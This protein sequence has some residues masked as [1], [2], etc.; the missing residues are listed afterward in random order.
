MTEKYYLEGVVKSYGSAF[1]GSNFFF[2]LS[3]STFLIEN[4]RLNS[5]L[6]DYKILF[7]IWIIFIIPTIKRKFKKQNFVSQFKKKS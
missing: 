1:E 4:L 5:G 2:E 3:A 7:V 6:L